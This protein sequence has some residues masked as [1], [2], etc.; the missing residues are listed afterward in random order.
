MGPF[1]EQYG[2]WAIV[3]GAAQGVG[4]A[5]AE[6]LLGRDC[7]VVLVDCLPEVQEVAAGLGS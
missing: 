2:P 6:S 4:L 3:T 5:F 7:S 1:A